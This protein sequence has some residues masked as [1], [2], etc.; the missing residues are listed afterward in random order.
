MQK[1]SKKILV[2]DDEESIHDIISLIFEEYNYTVQGISNSIDLL[3]KVLAY[4]PNLILLDIYLGET[5]GRLICKFL[6]ESSQTA[7]IPII[8]LS[9]TTLKLEQ[10]DCEADDFIEKPFEISEL[11]NKVQVLI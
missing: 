2:I 8:L 10:L 5:D 7:H 3:E 4:N 1:R 6:K 9:A 11:V